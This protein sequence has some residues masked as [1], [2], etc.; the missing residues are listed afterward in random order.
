MTGELLGLAAVLAL[1]LWIVRRVIAARRR[2][3]RAVAEIDHDALEAAERE[4]RDLGASV[5]EEDGFTGDDWGP[6]SG[7]NA[8]EIGL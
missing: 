4:V 3:P 6:G 2:Q 1:A 8:R 5:H 7:G